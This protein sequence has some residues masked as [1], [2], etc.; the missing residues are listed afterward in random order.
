MRFRYYPP[1]NPGYSTEMKEESVMDYEY[2]VGKIWQELFASG[3]YHDPSM[4]H[5]RL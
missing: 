4:A 1:L 5:K 3:K 2:P